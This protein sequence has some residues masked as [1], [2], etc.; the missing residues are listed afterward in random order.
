MKNDH[1]NLAYIRFIFISLE[2]TTSTKIY[3]LLANIQQAY[4]DP[5]NK[6]C[7]HL[8]TRYIFISVGLSSNFRNSHT[9][10]QQSVPLCGTQW[11]V[12]E[13]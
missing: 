11:Y 2:E 3:E 4:K 12:I 9:L 7:F 6:H 5:L 10:L 13:V 1:F 8:I